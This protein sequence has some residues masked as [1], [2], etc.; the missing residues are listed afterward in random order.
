MEGHEEGGKVHLQL[1]VPNQPPAPQ[2]RHMQDYVNPNKS[3][4]T[5]M[6]NFAYRCP[7]ICH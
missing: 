2:G 5:I 7:H 3:V 1:Q 4:D 6:H